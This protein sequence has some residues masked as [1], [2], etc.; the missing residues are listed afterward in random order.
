MTKKI[1]P[2]AIYVP[3]GTK[4]QVTI[5]QNRLGFSRFLIL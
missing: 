5:I 2:K 3:L 4:G 1:L